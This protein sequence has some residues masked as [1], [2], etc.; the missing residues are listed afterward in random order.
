MTFQKLQ[1]AV[2]PRPQGFCATPDDAIRLTSYRPRAASRRVLVIWIGA[3]LGADFGFVAKREGVS[4][5][6]GRTDSA[7]R[8]AIERDAN[9][10]FWASRK[11]RAFSIHIDSFTAEDLLKH[12]RFPSGIIPPQE[13]QLEA[14]RLIFS[15]PLLLTPAAKPRDFNRGCISKSG[16]Q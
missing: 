5:L 13:I 1:R 16:T 15:L 8:V 11:M 14:G 3:T 2:P 6:T 12:A 10:Q 9:G 4:L 7:L